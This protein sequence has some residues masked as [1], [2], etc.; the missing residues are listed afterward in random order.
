MNPRTST[1]LSLAALVLVLLLPFVARS[2]K[3]AA[4]G[5]AAPETLIVI[6]ASNESIRYEFTR[7]FRAH[8]ARKGRNVDVDWRS[9]GGA[10]AA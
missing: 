3:L 10:P 6:T 9:P 5:A 7:A 2:R 8:M 1:W 4:P